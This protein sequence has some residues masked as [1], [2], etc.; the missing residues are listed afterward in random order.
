MCSHQ[1]QTKGVDFK[2]RETDADLCGLMRLFSPGRGSR[3]GE[4]EVFF[5]C[6]KQ[7]NERIS[8][9]IKDN[10]RGGIRGTTFRRFINKTKAKTE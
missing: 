4:R 3:R 10:L 1:S 6:V 9:S 7:Q 2:Q 8:Y 5:I